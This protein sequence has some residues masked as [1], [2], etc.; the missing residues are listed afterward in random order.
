M[1]SVFILINL[2]S[3]NIRYSFCID[4]ISVMVCT[5][6]LFLRKTFRRAKTNCLK[7][8]TIFVANSN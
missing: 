8:L 6:S 2:I 5:C 7:L 3:P 4:I 1:K